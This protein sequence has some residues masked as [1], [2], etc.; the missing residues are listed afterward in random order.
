M[1]YTIDTQQN[2]YTRRFLGVVARGQSYL[3]IIYS[4]L[5]F[6]LGLFYFVFLITGLSVGLALFIIWI[7]IPILLFMLAAWWGLAV[8]E[9]QLAIW[10]LRADIPPMSRGSASG[11]GLWGGF[12]THLKNPVTWKA[13]AYLLARFPLG[14]LSFVVLVVAI[15]LTIG[16]LAA[17]FIY[18]SET[19][20][21]TNGHFS[22]HADMS[23][24]TI[25]PWQVDTLG[26]ALICSILGIGL[27]LSS[28][29]VI[30][31]LA[32]VSGRF[33][34]LMLGTAPSERNEP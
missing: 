15:G 9:R 5:A 18:Q 24:Y 34:R 33:A 31:G 23:E 13:L 12:K 19:I 29:H 14:I 32:F 30:N 8:F 10:L 26:E 3:N 27:G 22:F 7:G 4:L 20:A 16:L 6:P 28:M 11:E 21:F 25:G 2:T 17:P 1:N